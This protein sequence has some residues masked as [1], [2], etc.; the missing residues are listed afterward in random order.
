MMTTWLGKY[1]LKQLL[2]VYEGVF[3]ESALPMPAILWMH[4]L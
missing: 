3:L 4:R 1:T 2:F